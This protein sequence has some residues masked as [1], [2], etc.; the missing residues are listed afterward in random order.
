MCENAK[1]YIIFEIKLLD[2]KTENPFNCGI[3]KKVKLK[4]HYSKYGKIGWTKLVI[5]K[6][7]RLM[8][9]SKN[10]LFTI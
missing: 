7:G 1:Y 10:V 3:A 9:A 6:A 4:I 8:L 5:F 2:T